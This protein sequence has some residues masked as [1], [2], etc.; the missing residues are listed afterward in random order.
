MAGALLAQSSSGLT[1][2][3]VRHTSTIY[4]YHTRTNFAQFI[5]INYL[6]TMQFKGIISRTKCLNIS[7]NV[8]NLRD[9]IEITMQFYF[10][11]PNYSYFYISLLGN[12]LL[13]LL[14][15]FTYRIHCAA[16]FN[17]ILD[18]LIFDDM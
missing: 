18:K 13:K 16:M 1:L 17:G 6:S 7:I 5:F 11:N 14:N 10:N 15:Y 9:C 8:C 12:Q 3:Q 4:I 2:L